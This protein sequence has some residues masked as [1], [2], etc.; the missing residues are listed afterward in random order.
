M[1]PKLPALPRRPRVHVD[2][3]QRAEPKHKQGRP[4]RLARLEKPPKVVE[5]SNQ[6]IEDKPLALHR[7]ETTSRYLG[8]IRRKGDETR[9]CTTV[10]T[11]SRSL[12]CWV[13]TAKETLEKVLVVKRTVSRHE[14]DQYCHNF[15]TLA[16]LSQAILRLRIELDGISQRC[17]V[18]VV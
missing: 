11:E 12:Q 3:P 6:V 14:V 10:T 15:E 1:H 18:C 9:S 7:V 8:P 2:R 17:L 13:R 5:A 4:L 16:V